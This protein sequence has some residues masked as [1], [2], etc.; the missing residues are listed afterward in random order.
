L[1]F[2]LLRA[3]PASKCCFSAAA[4][5]VL[6]FFTSR[7]PAA[8]YFLQIVNALA[9]LPNQSAKLVA[10]GDNYPLWIPFLFSVAAKEIKVASELLLE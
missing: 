2:R 8:A 7:V 3:R 9:A 4:T 6:P 1:G 5:S 10:P